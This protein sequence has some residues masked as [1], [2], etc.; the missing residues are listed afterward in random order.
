M[1]STEAPALLRSASKQGLTTSEYVWIAMSVHMSHAAKKAFGQ[2]QRLSALGEQHV[3]RDG[4]E[5]PNG[6]I[7]VT[8]E[9][10]SSVPMRAIERGAVIW[11]EAIIGYAYHELAKHFERGANQS[12]LRARLRDAFA[13]TTRAA[14]PMPI[15][16]PSA[17]DHAS[18]RVSST[19]TAGTGT[20]LR[21]EA[22]C[23]PSA[24]NVSLLQRRSSKLLFEFLL[25][26]LN[27]HQSSMRA[28]GAVGDLGHDLAHQLGNSTAA[29]EASSNRTEASDAPPRP[30]ELNA[31]LA[32]SAAAALRSDIDGLLLRSRFNFY[33]RKNNGWSTV[34]KFAADSQIRNCIA[35]RQVNKI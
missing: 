1:F 5:L 16:I 31:S 32:A 27:A 21:N 24:A 14:A 30:E 4:A 13:Y 19:S 8:Y 26:R 35:N 23:E 34:I 20:R 10:D 12:E 6:L 3:V 18:P 25:E 22:K 2:Q 28:M 11:T 17:A 9:L 15:P 29:A 7:G 33:N